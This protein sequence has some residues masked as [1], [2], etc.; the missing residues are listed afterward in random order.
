MKTEN[1]C[2]NC[3]NIKIG[4]KNST[5]INT[6]AAGTQ[7]KKVLKLSDLGVTEDKFRKILF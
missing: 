7:E 6:N 2:N 1:E 3:L 4:D 5:K